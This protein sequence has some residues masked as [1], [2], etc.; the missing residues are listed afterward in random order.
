MSPATRLGTHTDG[1]IGVELR[2]AG[3]RLSLAYAPITPSL[4]VGSVTPLELGEW[5][6]RFWVLLHLG[7]DGTDGRVLAPDTTPPDADALIGHYRDLWVAFVASPAPFVWDVHE[8]LADI[9]DDLLQHGYFHHRTPLPSARWGTFRFNFEGGPIKFSAGLAHD[10]TQALEMARG[11]LASQNPE[12]LHRK[13]VDR[14]PQLRAADLGG[15]AEAVGDVVRWNTTWDAVNGRAVTVLSRNWAGPKFGGW[16]VWLDDFFY[17]ALLATMVD[18]EIAA[19]NADVVLSGQTPEGN[20][21]CL[22]TEFNEWVDRS[23][24]PIG[25]HVLWRLFLRTGDR[26]L[27]AR[28][29]PTLRRAYHWWF[30]HRDGN[31]NRLLEYGSSQTGTGLYRRTALAAR[32]ESSMDNSPM[33]DQAVF[34]KETGTLDLEDVALNSLLAVEAEA[35]ARIAAMLGELADAAWFQAERDA[36]VTRIREHLW[37]KD[38]QIF[39]NRFW[40][41]RFSDRHS[42]TSFFPLAAGAATAEQAEALVH[43]HL[44]NPKRFL[45]DAGLPAIA[46]DDPAARDNVYWRGRMWPPLN[47][48]VYEGLM[49][50]G[51][52]QE[53][54]RLAETGARRFMDEWQRE[55]HCHE[56]FA[57]FPDQPTD[58]ADSDSF[59]TWGALLPFIGTMVF[60]DAD[61][62]RGLQ[63]GR[64][65][66]PASRVE[67]GPVPFASGVCHLTQLPD[68]LSLLHNG[69]VTLESTISGRFSQVVVDGATIGMTIPAHE[70][71]GQISLPALDPAKITAGFLDEESLRIA[72][73]T[74]V[75]VKLPSSKKPCRL[76][77]HL[78]SG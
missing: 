75:R 11:A 7:F 51:Y 16:G 36:M 50:Y 9:T 76:T 73:G 49:R 12:M 17:H 1:A 44:L 74:P 40:S 19:Q 60:M 47:F 78:R 20:L 72:P 10:R 34:Q 33:Y 63:I 32:D 8:R 43:R 15:L 37:D 59:Y 22:L 6:L 61:P 46:R 52:A 57:V 58:T 68:R 30:A 69:V 4:L 18:S 5:G 26:P 65:V 55:R 14:R 41:G 66:P 67:I 27:L 64:A 48:W 38:H 54:I 2:H 21:P 24:P 28:A 56:N 39:A 71:E 70:H 13:A 62:W 31:H 25:A 23:Q 35:L 77:I 45:D 53:A 3:T 29:Y 42:P